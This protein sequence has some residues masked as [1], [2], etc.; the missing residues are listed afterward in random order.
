MYKF[1]GTV[2]RRRPRRMD[3]RPAASRTQTGVMICLRMSVTTQWEPT[4]AARRVRDSRFRTHS[5]V[6]YT[7]KLRKAA[8]HV[9]LTIS[10]L[11]GR[12]IAFSFA[13]NLSLIQCRKGSR[14]FRE[15]EWISRTGVQRSPSAERVVEGRGGGR[16]LRNTE[17]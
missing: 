2:G 9:E 14:I 15:G 7:A 4:C 12:D 5:R 16:R 8:C 13:P 3:V 10:G 1:Q 6:R 17:V 11:F